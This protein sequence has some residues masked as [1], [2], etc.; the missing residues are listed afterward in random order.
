MNKKKTYSN[1]HYSKVAQQ[2]VSLYVDSFSILKLKKH[3]N[4]RCNL[5]LDNK[6]VSNLIAYFLLINF[7][8]GALLPLNL[9][10]SH[11][12]ASNFIHDDMTIENDPCHVAIYHKTS[13]RNQCEHKTHISKHKEVCN[14]CTGVN[15][16]RMYVTL[17]Y[18]HG[19]SIVMCN[20]TYSTSKFLPISLHTNESYLGRAPPFI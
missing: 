18:Q 4:S 13:L 7:I 8:V 11:F 5:V 17:E 2:N 16:R 9:L 20:K 10:H 19:L 1:D 3:F 6:D 14:D 12:E 15:N